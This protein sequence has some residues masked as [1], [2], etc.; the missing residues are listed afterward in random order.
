M[1]RTLIFTQK[2]NSLQLRAGERFRVVH[3][4]MHLKISNVE[5]TPYLSKPFSVVLVFAG[6]RIS[7]V[8]EAFRAEGRDAGKAY[9]GAARENGITNG[10][11]A[12]VVDTDD[13]S[14]VGS[15]R[16]GDATQIFQK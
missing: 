15:L 12:W 11:V 13:I 6:I 7:H 14:R 1:V 4:S 5:C 10:E 8:G 16:G 3:R 9:L 2:K